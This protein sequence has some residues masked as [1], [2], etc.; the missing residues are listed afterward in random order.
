MDLVDVGT[1]GARPARTIALVSPVDGP[2]LQVLVAED[3]AVNQRV[4]L[5]YLDKLGH[6]ADVAANGLEVIQAL[7]RQ[8]YDVVLMDMH[9][10]E[11]DGLDA[12]RAIHKRWP[13]EERPRIVAVTAN[14]ISGDRETCIEAGMDDYVSKPMTMEELAEALGRCRT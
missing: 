10:P 6:N 1:D 9:M 12:T 14:A 2:A 5:L 13:K 8:R 7:E 3:N 11:M 4:A